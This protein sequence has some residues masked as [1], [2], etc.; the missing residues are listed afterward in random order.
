MTGPEQQADLSQ[1]SIDAIVAGAVQAFAAAGSLA[2]LKEARLAHAG[3]RSPIALANRAIGMLPGVERK[4]AGQRIGAGRAA[5]AA[6]LADRE[7][8]IG[9][10]ELEAR[11]VAETVDV[12]L[13][14]VSRG[15]GSLFPVHGVIGVDLLSHCRVTLDS[16][17]ARLTALP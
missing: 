12:T 15:A 3:D 14:V 16:G 4:D 6:A 8:E 17:R 13:P 7:A 1:A 11:L 5:I 2:E 9:S 10:A